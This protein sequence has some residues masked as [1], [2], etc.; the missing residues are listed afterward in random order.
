MSST[1]NTACHNTPC[2][3]RIHLH[4]PRTANRP[5]AQASQP[6]TPATPHATHMPHPAHIILHTFRP[7]CLTHI[8]HSTTSLASV[9]ASYHCL[10]CLSC[11]LPPVTFTLHSRNS[12]S[13]HCHP[14]AM[15][16]QTVSY[17]NMNIL[18]RPPTYVI[19][20]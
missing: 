15:S 9:R 14:Y 10:P 3:L 20:Y 5:N 16:Y 8:R 13:I 4:V 19:K 18:C 7:A 2:C 1:S 12:C 6:V 11:L 17:Y